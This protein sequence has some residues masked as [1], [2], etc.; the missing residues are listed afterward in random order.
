[1]QHYYL[2]SAQVVYLKDKLE[3]SRN[4]NI[5][6]VSKEPRV[7]RAQLG[8]VQQQAQVRFFTEFDTEH[9]SEVTDVFIM[10][11]NYLGEMTEAQF[12]EGFDLPS[13]ANGKAQEE[14]QEEEASLNMPKAEPEE[15]AEE[16]G[17]DAPERS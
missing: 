3:R 6:V 12:H 15:E 10:A 7:T 11:V 17:N 9:K 4:Y 14:S 5:L 1:M 8:R 2:I 16:I 13:Q